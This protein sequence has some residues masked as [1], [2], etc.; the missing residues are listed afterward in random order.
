M[1]NAKVKTNIKG[2]QIFAIPAAF[3]FAAG[4]IYALARLC[5][6]GVTAAAAT[7]DL[8]DAFWMVIIGLAILLGLVIAFAYTARRYHEKGKRDGG[9]MVAQKMSGE[10]K[11]L[12]QR[13]EELEEELRRR[14][15]SKNASHFILE[16][17]DD[18]SSED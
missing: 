10:V 17:E 18:A 6:A 16:A 1:K 3:V 15:T 13:V 5:Y 11:R 8:K 12:N 14:D 7:F 9:S 2:W 4:A